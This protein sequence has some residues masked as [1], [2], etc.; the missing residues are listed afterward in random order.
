MQLSIAKGMY[1]NKLPNIVIDQVYFESME[2]DGINQVS[3]DLLYQIPADWTSVSPYRV[4]LIMTDD[5]SVIHGFRQHPSTAKHAIRDDTGQT[6][7]YM[8]MYLMGDD[9]GEVSNFDEAMSL[10]NNSTA[11]IRQRRVGVELPDLRR[12]LWPSMYIYAIA[13]RVNPQDET[14]SGITQKLSAIRTGFPLSETIY[15]E[16]Y[17]SPQAFVYKLES[18]VD[19]YG[20]QGDLWSGPTHRQEGRLMAG[21]LHNT[22]P[23]PYLSI[24]VVSNQKTQDKSFM[25]KQSEL[26]LG[27]TQASRE[28]NRRMTED[29]EVVQNL[30][31]PPSNG[32]SDMHFT[33][34]TSGVLK[35]VFSINYKHFVQANTKM[36]FL[37]RNKTALNGCFEVENL[38]LFRT[39]I[40]SSVASNRLTP[41]VLNTCGPGEQGTPKL[42][43]TLTGGNISGI[44]YQNQAPGVTTYVGTD[45]E[46]AGIEGG[47]YE[48]TL[49]VD[50][51]DS[52]A[53]AANHVL[54]I[55]KTS[56]TAYDGWIS[57]NFYG[58]YGA[59]NTDASRRIRSQSQF[60]QEDASWPNLIDT[61][62]AAV[63]FI[64]GAEAFQD[65]SMV[66]WRKNLLAMCNPRNG[67]LESMYEVSELVRNFYTLLDKAVNPPTIGANNNTFSVRSGISTTSAAAKRISLINVFPSLYDHRFDPSTG[68]DFLDDEL[69]HTSP[70][71]TGISYTNYSVR[72][73]NEIGKYGFSPEG[74]NWA[75]FLTPAR[76][77]TP[78]NI[79]NTSTMAVGLNNTIDLLAAK[80]RPQ[81]P[82]LSFHTST[83]GNTPSGASIDELLSIGG[84]TVQPLVL[85]IQSIRNLPTPT[86]AQAAALSLVSSTDYLSSGSAFVQDDASQ[87]SATSGSAE[88]NI[89][90]SHEEINNPTVSIRHSGLVMTVLNSQVE[91][92][93]QPTGE[94]H[95]GG[96]AGSLASNALAHTPLL[97]L[98][99]N[100]VTIAISFNSIK[101]VQ[102]FQGFETNSRGDA[103]ISAPMW[104][105]LTEVIY[106]Q[107]KSQGDRLLCRTQDTPD[108]CAGGNILELGEY[109]N[110]FILGDA[111]SATTTRAFMSYTFYYATIVQHLGSTA[112][113]TAVNI[114]TPLSNV[115][116]F[117]IRL[118]LQ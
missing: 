75:G 103:L 84:L 63:M 3:L 74:T 117:L 86:A 30:S 105:I 54:G 9:S 51:V 15:R 60:L 113:Q 10:G 81:M 68:F 35:A 67:D 12:D 107:A 45:I 16:N 57:Q 100:A 56:L 82:K 17:T 106:N 64:F 33:R 96:I 87:L 42:V 7:A 97:L 37:F 19:G 27:I 72:T 26:F 115:K 73:N 21:D 40:R 89:L 25:R 79:I 46:M 34:N 112:T 94:Y 66:S 118:P 69:V 31:G 52:S 14:P 47:S 101:E 32:I 38:R 92:F 4:M 55:L 48:Y 90:Y 43:G 61:Y 53:V 22:G 71:L 18:T 59:P 111:S 6:P 98:E 76:I 13:Y 85:D 91:G 108:V 78:T 39:R 109:D 83:P 104:S 95:V 5:T 41:G 8:K 11:A 58:Q 50:G 24:T 23:H 1:R 93:L 36:N 114:K 20:N 99:N 62:L 2:E 80:L 116:P 28:L 29:M 70:T 65:H 44:G 77:R 110:L 88:Q 49:Y 102:Y